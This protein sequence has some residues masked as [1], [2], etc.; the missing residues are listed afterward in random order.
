MNIRIMMINE[1]DGKR[2]DAFPTDISAIPHVSDVI[3]S[4][5]QNTAYIVTERH[6]RYDT[7]VLHEV[8][9]KVKEKR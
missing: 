9:L 5:R 2:F 7:G 3:T 1:E 6:F 4:P 8:H